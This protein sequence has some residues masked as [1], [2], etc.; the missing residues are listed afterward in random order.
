MEKSQ[1]PVGGKHVS[2]L[3]SSSCA[4]TE[5][6]S[7]LSQE[8]AHRSLSAPAL[9]SRAPCGLGNTGLHHEKDRISSGVITSGMFAPCHE[10]ASCHRVVHFQILKWSVV[11][12]VRWLIRYVAW[13]QSF[14]WRSS[15]LL[16]LLI[17]LVSP[18]LAKNPK[19]NQPGFCQI[20]E[21]PSNEA[22]ECNSKIINWTRHPARFHQY[23]KKGPHGLF[24]NEIIHLFSWK[25]FRM[26][27]SFMTPHR[28]ISFL[29]LSIAAITLR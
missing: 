9:P 11:F 27:R 17:C 21:I 8:R 22:L 19:A 13:Q 4:P 28:T 26:Y 6:P 29:P 12:Y 7:L 14:L 2:L 25:V 24:K 3:H 23:R 18:F 10:C 20:S 1:T 16:V 5:F 15:V